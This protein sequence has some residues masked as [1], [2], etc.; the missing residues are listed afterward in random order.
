VAFAE[1][2]AR[3]QRRLYL[4]ASRMCSGAGDDVVQDTF[5][6][7]LRGTGAF[8]PQRGSAAGYLFGIARHF[9]LKQLGS[10]YDAGSADRLEDAPGAAAAPETVLE[11][12]TRAETVHAVRAAVEQLPPVFRE[13]VVLCELQ[14]MD[15]ATAAE[16]LQC[17]IGTV[18]SRLHR[19]R[20]L[21][22]TA[23]AAERPVARVRG[24]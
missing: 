14:E 7:V 11:T 5:L 6:T 3:Y 23:L 10:R 18:R 16:V 4:Y 19:A 15:Y 21:L 20:S 22:L 13:V 24:A 1:L 12:L 2:F 17:P 8:D 9:I